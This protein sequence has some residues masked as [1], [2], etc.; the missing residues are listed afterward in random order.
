MLFAQ[1][2]GQEREKVG[3]KTSEHRAR[4]PLPNTKIPHVLLL[5]IPFFPMGKKEGQAKANQGSGT[6]GTTGTNWD[7][8]MHG[9]AGD[10]RVGMQVPK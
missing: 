3:M 5:I 2:H 10:Q 6:L 7:Q 8:E 4:A 9:Q 1:I